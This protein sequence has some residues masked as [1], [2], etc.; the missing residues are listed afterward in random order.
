MI[1][2]LLYQHISRD[3]I[4]LNLLTDQ[5]GRKI[6]LR[7]LKHQ[8]MI[9]I[10][11]KVPDQTRIKLLHS[12]KSL[13]LFLGNCVSLHTLGCR[14][15]GHVFY[16]IM[17]PSSRSGGRGG[18]I[19]EEERHACL[20]PACPSCPHRLGALDPPTTSTN[21][22][23]SRNSSNCFQ[24]QTSCRPTAWLKRASTICILSASLA[25]RGM[26]TQNLIMTILVTWV[27]IQWS[28]G[29]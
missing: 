24:M 10:C 29:R 18:G 16:V 27:S 2:S 25:A 14:K 5:W 3:A 4:P 1:S 12:P 9:K 11:H 17:D 21:P 6:L 8:I 22:A 26:A 7:I 20:L 23:S 13:E 19:V 28:E 15:R